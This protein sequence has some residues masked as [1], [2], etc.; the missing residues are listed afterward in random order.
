MRKTAVRCEEKYDMRSDAI[1]SREGLEGVRVPNIYRLWVRWRRDI[2]VVHVFRVLISYTPSLS[3]PFKPRKIQSRR[4]KSI[5]TPKV[6]A[7][8][9]ASLARTPAHETKEEK[10]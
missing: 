10:I 9:S 8:A 3:G 5:Y 2:S 4:K 1:C 6:R 7:P